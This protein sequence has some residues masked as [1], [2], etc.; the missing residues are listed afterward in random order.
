MAIAD[1]GTLDN[2]NSLSVLCLQALKNSVGKRYGLSRRRWSQDRQIDEK[3][4]DKKSK[5]TKT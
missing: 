2:N 3:Q 5:S 4:K 1:L